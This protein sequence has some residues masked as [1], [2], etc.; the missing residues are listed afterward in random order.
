MNFKLEITEL[1]EEEYS[2]AFRYYEEQQPGLG[3]KFEKEAD[4][5]IDKL[6]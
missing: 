2:S 5:L 6:K 3:D 1:A 4:Y